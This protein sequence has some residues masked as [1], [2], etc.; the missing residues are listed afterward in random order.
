VE[1]VTDRVGSDHAD[2]ATKLLVER[3]HQPFAIRTAVRREEL[4][5]KVHV[6][7]LGERVHAGVRAT[8]ATTRGSSLM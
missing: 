8:S 5:R 6:H 3:P 1:L 4:H 2:P 7:D